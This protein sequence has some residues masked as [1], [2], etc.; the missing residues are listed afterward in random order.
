[1]DV[2]VGI[3]K[4]GYRGMDK[5][6]GTTYD[7]PPG[8]QCTTPWTQNWVQCPPGYY[9][10]DTEWSCL[11]CPEGKSCALRHNAAVTLNAGYWS[12]YGVHIPL[13]VPAGWMSNPT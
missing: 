10:P 4:I 13:V 5:T 9:S 12:P 7:C 6:K 1:M 8:Y 3:G 2:E 11:P